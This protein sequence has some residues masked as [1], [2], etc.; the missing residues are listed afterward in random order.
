MNNPI[1][2]N[3]AVSRDTDHALR[4]FLASQGG[5]KK[6]DLSRF[7]EQAVRAY[8]MDLTVE[9]AKAANISVS[10]NKLTEIVK[11]AL[12]WASRDDDE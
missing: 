8:I 12:D 6:G 4:L 3:I 2:W 9:Q 1:H 7:V 11:E 5:E 10:E